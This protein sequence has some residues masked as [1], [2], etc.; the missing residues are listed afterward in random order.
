LSGLILLS[1]FNICSGTLIFCDDLVA[2][3]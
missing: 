3:C 1:L 2:L